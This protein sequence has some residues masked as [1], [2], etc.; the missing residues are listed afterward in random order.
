M[1]V[2]VRRVRIP[3][4]PLEA[5]RRGAAVQGVAA[6]P[7]EG[8]GPP[9]L[10]ARVEGRAGRAPAERGADA[11]DEDA[12][13]AVSAR[14]SARA[15]ARAT[16]MRASM[17]GARAGRAGERRFSKLYYIG[18]DALTLDP[19]ERFA[20]LGLA[21]FLALDDARIALQVPRGFQRRSKRRVVVL[22]RDG[23]AVTNL[24]LIHI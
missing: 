5:A 19:G 23:D 17:C 1:K 12:V 10:L 24:S 15:E 14:A 3:P 11:A 8:P 16:V 18:R 22:Q 6:A 13:S 20:R 2:V 21:R 7:A 9:Q 4:A